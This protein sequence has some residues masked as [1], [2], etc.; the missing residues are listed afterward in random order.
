MEKKQTK[1]KE[2]KERNTH[3]IITTTVKIDAD[4]RNWTCFFNCTRTAD[5]DIVN[6]DTINPDDS[7]KEIPNS[8]I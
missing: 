3:E 6:K 7:K 2:K 1:Q 4:A 8:R 5:K